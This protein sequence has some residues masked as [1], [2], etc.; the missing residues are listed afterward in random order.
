MPEDS[1][2]PEVPHQRTFDE[3]AAEADAEARERYLVE[4]RENDQERKAPYPGGQPLPTIRESIRATRESLG[5]RSNEE[6]GESIPEG[7]G[8]DRAA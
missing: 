2:A 1:E 6:G 8:P 4:L 3:A 7:T 5:I